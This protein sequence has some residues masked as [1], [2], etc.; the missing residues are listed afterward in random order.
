MTHLRIYPSYRRARSAFEDLAK[1]VADIPGYK[2]MYHNLTITY[3]GPY[4]KHVTTKF[5]SLERP[6]QL[7]GWSPDTVF[8]EEN[9]TRSQVQ[10]F[11]PEA[12]FK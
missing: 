7:R 10:Q 8:L 5:M 4:G 12:K 2:V 1:S 9:V 11:F 6:E 3:M